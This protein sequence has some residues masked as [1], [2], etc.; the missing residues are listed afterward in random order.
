[1]EKSPSRAISRTDIVVALYIFFTIISEVMGAK[2]F[3][4]VTIGSFQLSTSVAIFV[5]PFV[6]SLSD[7]MLEVHGKKRARG[8]VYLGIGTIV[9]LMLYTLLATSLPP[10]SRF[11]P[12]E[13]AYDAIFQFSIRMSL[14]SIAAFALS[15]LLD[16]A[17]FSK[18]RE[19]MH[20]KALWV[21]NNVS[22]FVGFF[23]DSAVFL[24]IAFY[25]PEKS[26]ADNFG[27]IL[28]LLIPYWLLK[29]FMSV[30][31][32]P[33]VYAGVKWLKRDAPIAQ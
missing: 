19:R 22:N 10:T 15:E 20:K 30:I 9:L 31:E 3:P 26:L 24:V 11:A 6:F 2:T 13:P 29:C 18:L 25:A 14:A 1:M 4:I 27:F 8:L 16:L 32:T 17:I 12:S 23:V 7:I 33:F 5:L 21:R 28:S